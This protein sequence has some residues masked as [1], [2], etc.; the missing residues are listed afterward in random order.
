MGGCTGSPG[1]LEAEWERVGGE[2]N[3]V[4]S[5]LAT[6]N[7]DPVALT[8]KRTVPLHF[9]EIIPARVNRGVPPEE[10]WPRSPFSEAQLNY[11]PD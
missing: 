4:S 10:S 5:L 7:N 9:S 11:S 2:V 8:Q 1:D 3:Q 6:P